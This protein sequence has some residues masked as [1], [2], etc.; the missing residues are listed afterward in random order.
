MMKDGL[1]HTEVGLPEGYRH[2]ACAVPVTYSLHALNEARKDRYGFIPCPE[3]LGLSRFETVEV[4]VVGGRLSKIVVRGAMTETK[5]VVYVLI[6][7]A[8][9]PWFCKTVWVNLKSDSHR[10]LDRSRYVR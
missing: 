10:T 7:K 4:E 8:G 9:K 1:Y 6:P 5:D 2:P 3:L